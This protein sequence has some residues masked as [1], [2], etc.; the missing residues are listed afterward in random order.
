MEME[1]LKIEYEIAA[2]RK[3]H[4]LSEIRVIE[5]LARDIGGARHIPEKGMFDRIWKKGRPGQILVKGCAAALETFGFLCAGVI[6]IA[7]RQYAKRMT[8]STEEIYVAAA[9]AA[10]GATAFY[11]LWRSI[12]PVLKAHAAATHKMIFII[13]AGVA[14]TCT[15]AM[16]LRQSG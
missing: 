11:L 1:I 13:S 6:L 8:L 10:A 7:L 4:E 14:V 2:L 12:S 16:W 5:S 9:V 3:T 15:T